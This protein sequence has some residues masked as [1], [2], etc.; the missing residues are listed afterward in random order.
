M[1]ARNL[2][3]NLRDSGALDRRPAGP[4]WRATAIFF[5]FALALGAVVYVGLAF[6][7]P[8]LGPLMRKPAPVVS[9]AKPSSGVLQT[10][11]VKPF[12]ETDALACKRYAKGV[13]KRIVAARERAMMDATNFDQVILSANTED[14]HGLVAEVTCI[15]QTRPMRFCDP[16]QRADLAQRIR[17]PLGI[18]DT[19]SRLF[20]GQLPVGA[21]SGPHA[22]MLT[23]QRKVASIE[24]GKA[25]AQLIRVFRDLASRGLLSAGDFGNGFLGGTPPALAPAF[26]DLK[27]STSV[28]PPPV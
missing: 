22:D 8:N 21:P 23:Q 19:L 7:L 20:G 9:Y 14:F 3:R 26:A 5:C 17:E 16:A 11:A 4:E 27:S 13:E 6:A 2:V 18:L 12:S 1:S 15:A 28:C 25:H 24:F 10:L